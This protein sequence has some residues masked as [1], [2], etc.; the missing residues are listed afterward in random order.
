MDDARHPLWHLY[1][2]IE[3]D[4]KALI[5][6]VSELGI[7]LSLAD[8]PNPTDLNC[9]VC[10]LK[11]RGPITLSEHLYRSHGGDVPETWDHIERLSIDPVASE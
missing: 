1:Y 10:G 8:L 2:A 3:Q 11:T 7:Q 5:A 6:K 9:P 4:T